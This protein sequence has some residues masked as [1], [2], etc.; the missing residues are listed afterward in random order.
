MSLCG[1]VPCPLG[2]DC[3]FFY[4]FRRDDE[5]FL[6]VLSIKLLKKQDKPKKEKMKMP[7]QTIG[8]WVRNFL[9]RENELYKPQKRKNENAGTNYWITGREFFKTS[10]QTRQNVKLYIFIHASVTSSHP[11]FSS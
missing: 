10:K 8:L 4:A 7:E 11:S 1:L 9:K 2:R 3:S 5:K 6:K